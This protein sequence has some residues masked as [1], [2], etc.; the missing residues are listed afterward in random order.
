MWIARINA[1]QDSMECL[2]ASLWVKLKQIHIDLNRKVLADLAMNHPD[3]F[4]A[5]LTKSNNYKLPS[6]SF[7]LLYIVKNLSQPPLSKI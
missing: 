2:T 4:K 7:F 6:G 1:A 3:A 5:L